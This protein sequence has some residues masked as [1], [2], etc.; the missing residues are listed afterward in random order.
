MSVKLTV[1]EI[2]GLTLAALLTV[3]EK[4][5]AVSLPFWTKRTS[6]ASI[7]AMVKPP[8][9]AEGQVRP[10][11]FVTWNSPPWTEPDCSEKKSVLCALVT[12]KFASDSTRVPPSLIASVKLLRTGGSTNGKPWK[13]FAA[14][15]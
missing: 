15:A 12:L 6:P 4:V 3:I 1:G 5:G 8:V 2:A 7:C 14:L 9:G 10:S 13:M 11:L